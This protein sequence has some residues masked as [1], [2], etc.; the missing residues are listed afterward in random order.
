MCRMQKNNPQPAE[1][2]AEI[3]PRPKG[4]KEMAN[5]NYQ[6]GTETK[7]LAEIWAIFEQVESTIST[8]HET[9]TVGRNFGQKMYAR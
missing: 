3:L 6:K 9:K 2:L 5:T 4:P 1:K 7:K 8:S